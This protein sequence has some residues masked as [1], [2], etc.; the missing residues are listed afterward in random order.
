M[1]AMPYGGNGVNSCG[2]GYSICGDDALK[3][4][5]VA[6]PFRGKTPWDVAQNVRAAEEVG[7]GIARIGAYP[8]I[9][10]AMTQHFD[11]QLS[12][13]FWLNGTM[14][15]L[16]RCDALITTPNWRSSVGATAEVQEMHK[17]QRP[18]FHDV[19]QLYNWL[20]IDCRYAPAEQVGQG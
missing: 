16:R 4:V 6:G 18:V 17:L 8:V 14:E 10:H 19:V 15:L 20:T 13:E 2:N 7:L 12:D 11:K 1:L 5:Y 3:L 9:P